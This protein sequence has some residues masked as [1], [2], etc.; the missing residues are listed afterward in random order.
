[1]D[2]EAAPRQAIW[3][4]AREPATPCPWF[5]CPNMVH[6]TKNLSETAGRAPRVASLRLVEGHAR[7]HLHWRQSAA[8]V[9]VSGGVPML[10]QGAP[11]RFASGASFGRCA[12]SRLS[13]VFG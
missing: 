7:Q 1:M 10:P 2:P 11:L 5:P 3:R 8:P 9:Q 12:R 4:Q 6:N 13:Q